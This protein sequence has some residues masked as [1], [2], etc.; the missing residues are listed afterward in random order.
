[1]VL[2]SATL[3]N[4]R[5]LGNW[6]IILGFE[7]NTKLCQSLATELNFRA[8]MIQ[9]HRFPDGE[10]KVTIP[11]QLEETVIFLCSLNDPNNK[12]IELMLAVQWARKY[13]CQRA[14]LVAPYLCYMRQDC[15]FEP[16]QVV[17]Q[18]IMGDWLSSLFDG[19]IT[20]DPHLHRID[21][22]DQAFLHCKAI[23]VSAT[24]IIGT[25]LKGRYEQAVLVGPDEESQQWVSVVAEHS[26]LEYCVASK[27]R[28]GDRDVSV[29]LPSFDFTNRT[30]ILVDD[31]ISSGHTIQQAALALK[32]AGANK[33]LAA[34]THP[35][36]ATGAEEAL[37][38]AGVES[39]LSC[40]TIA[41]SSN[42]IDISSLL[43]KT[44]HQQF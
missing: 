5:P 43:A 18:T 36:F 19:V 21:R 34:C 3:A 37:Q 27:V 1:M 33:V 25:Y 28:T 20:I 39:V 7:E 23:S 2:K 26:G 9:V 42:C 38:L 8:A 22:L 6:M 11:T 35:L 31:V 29:Q 41:H 4:N 12:L 30:A 15:E 13:G 32:E 40:N 14:I 10:S 44:I 17:S 16:G 24:E